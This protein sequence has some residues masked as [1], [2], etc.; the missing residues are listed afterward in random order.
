VNPFASAP[1][2]KVAMFKKLV[3]SATWWNALRRDGARVD[4]ESFLADWRRR[5]QIYQQ[6]TQRYWLYPE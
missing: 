1:A 5:A 2:D 3:G 6:Q 4:V